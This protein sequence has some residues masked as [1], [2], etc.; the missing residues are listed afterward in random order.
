MNDLGDGGN[1]TLLLLNRKIGAAV[2]LSF[3]SDDFPCLIEWKQLGLDE[4]VLGLEPATCAPPSLWKG[5]AP[6]DL[7]VLPPGSHRSFSFRIRL[8]T[9]SGEIEQKVEAIKGAR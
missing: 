5:Q 4:Y 1:V 9:D 3:S 7:P 2:A 6:R 8:I